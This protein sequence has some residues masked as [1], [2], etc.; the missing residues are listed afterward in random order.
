MLSRAADSL[1]WLARYIERAEDTARLL[2]VEFHGLLDRHAANPEE[3]WRE[4]LR[5]LGKQ[6]A[7][8]EHFDEFT[9]SAVT[10][11]LLWHPGNPD[12]VTACVEAARENA[13]SVRDQ[14]STEMWE[15]V[16]RLFLLVTDVD[17]ASVL[18]SPHRF[19]VRLRDGSHGFLGVTEATMERGEGYQFL[20]LGTHLERADMGARVLNAAF[21]TSDGT[22]ADGDPSPAQMIDLL[23]SCGAFEAFRR[24]AGAGARL[25]PTRVAEYLLLDRAFPRAV[26]YC[27]DTC[28][29]VV[30]AVSGPSGG[31]ERTIGRLCAE[32]AFHDVFDV[33]ADPFRQML[34]RVQRSIAESGNE[35]A[36][37]YFITRVLAPAAF[38]Q[39]QQQ[40]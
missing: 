25:T 29:E 35:I 9:A 30:R 34:A 16:N 4:F 23:K 14:L 27:L 2:D 19:F 38:A 5:T 1:F 6:D 40:Q 20:R 17:R 11:F 39:A 12:S 24:H 18:P 3:A 37:A 33:S 15:R 28:L 13:R 36:D 22:Y 10:S 8:S 21:V 32:L 26:L 7:F 31:P